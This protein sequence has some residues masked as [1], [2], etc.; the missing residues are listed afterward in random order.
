MDSGN[1]RKH[2][3]KT[4]RDLKKK[5]DLKT[6]D[7]QKHCRGSMTREARPKKRDWSSMTEEAWQKKHDWKSV[8]EQAWQKKRDRRNVT[9]EAWQK[10]RD[11][12]NITNERNWRKETPAQ[13][14]NTQVFTTQKNATLKTSCWRL[15]H[16]SI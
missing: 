4:S 14:K 7:P 3:K 10:K 15:R 1:L 5:R 6:Y 16:V 11:R 8:T 13:D 9:K 2:Y 12:Q